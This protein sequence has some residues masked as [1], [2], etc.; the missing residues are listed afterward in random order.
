L[1]GGL[2]SAELN[3]GV[4][5]IIY[6]TKK[7]ST[8]SNA[9]VGEVTGLD[10]SQPSNI[11]ADNAVE[12]VKLDM[13]DST[14]QDGSQPTN[15]QFDTAAET[16]HIEAKTEDGPQ[17]SKNQLEMAIET[18]TLNLIQRV[19]YLML[20]QRLL[21]SPNLRSTNLI[22]QQRLLTWKLVQRIAP[23]LLR[24]KLIL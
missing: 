16:A 7:T 12:T 10:G 15:N 24:T 13:D 5:A 21:T 3:S 17:P 19:A 23:N 2:D 22:L 9:P 4:D 20:Q 18:L 8:S 1:D 6:D 14:L 11:Q